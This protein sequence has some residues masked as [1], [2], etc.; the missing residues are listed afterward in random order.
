MC[1]QFIKVEKKSQ[2]ENYRGVAIQC[3]IPKILD[4]IIAKHLNE[5]VKNILTD[6][7]H[8]FVA[9]KSTITN[10]TEYTTNVSNGM[11]THKQVD[12][13][14]L[15]QRKAFDSVIIPLLIHKLRIMGLNEQILNWITEFLEGRQQMVKI[16]SNTISNTIDVTSGV[17]QGSPISSTLFNLLLFD[18]PLIMIHVLLSLFADDSK[19]FL[20][21]NTIDDCYILQNE[22]NAAGKYFDI[23]CLKLNEK[24]SKLITFHKKNLPIMFEYKL[25]DVAIERVETIKDLGIILDK[26]FRFKDHIDYMIGKAKSVLVWIKRFSYE[27]NDPWIIKRLFET[28]VIT[29]LEYGTLNL[30]L[31]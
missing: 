21:I 20:P 18:F 19:L 1:D 10:L 7:Q 17:G 3:V 28:F 5:Y 30:I 26:K 14:Y 24:K 15:D 25:N 9:G 23:N 6:H 22:L 4:S 2:V 16:D 27:F 8:G 13:I 31:I 29:I 11:H 12:A